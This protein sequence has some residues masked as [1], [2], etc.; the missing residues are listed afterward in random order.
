[1]NTPALAAE[2]T[3]F[4]VAPDGTE[5]EVTIT[6]G[7]PTPG[8][9]GGWSAAVSLGALEA[10]THSITGVDSWQAIC[11]AMSF[12]ATRV[13]HFAEDGWKFYWERGGDIASAEDLASVP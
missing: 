13:G 12:A 5:S 8:T 6:V 2:R 11:L 3:W 4:A 1:M 9:H 10:R 7:I